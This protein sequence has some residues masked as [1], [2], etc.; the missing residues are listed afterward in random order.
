MNLLMVSL[1]LPFVCSTWLSA[2]PTIPIELPNEHEF[3]RLQDVE[4]ITKEG[5]TA[6]KGSAFKTSAHYMPWGSHLHIDLVAS[7]QNE[8]GDIS[9]VLIGREIYRFRRNDFDDGGRF[10]RFFSYLD[11]SDPKVEKIVIETFTQ[12]HSDTCGSENESED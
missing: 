3:I 11:L 9:E 4:I 5:R 1:S 7:V 6:L 12:K 2:Q 8:E 10:E